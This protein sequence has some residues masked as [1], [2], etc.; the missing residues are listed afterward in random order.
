MPISRSHKGTPVRVARTMRGKCGIC[1]KMIMPGEAYETC[2][3]G[4][5]SKNGYLAHYNCNK[6]TNAPAWEELLDSNKRLLRGN[7]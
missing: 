4:T 3:G 2:V 1:H 7:K 5:N 6:P